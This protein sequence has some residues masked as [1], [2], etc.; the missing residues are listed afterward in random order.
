MKKIF[1]IILFYIFTSC[2]SFV[3]STNDICGL[4]TGI[5]KW[6]IDPDIQIC[7]NPDGTFLYKE[8]FDLYTGSGKGKWKIIGRKIIMEFNNEDSIS[9]IERVLSGGRQIKGNKSA[10]ILNRNKIKIKNVKLKKRE[11]QTED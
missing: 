1:Y 4:Y 2:H 6:P 9:D 7:F 8:S 3:D 11:T 10:V 5:S